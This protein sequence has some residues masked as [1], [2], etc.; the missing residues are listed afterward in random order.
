MCKKGA[1]GESWRV[2]IVITFLVHRSKNMDIPRK[3]EGKP[4]EKSGKKTI[5]NISTIESDWRKLRRVP[6]AE[7]EK[8]AERKTSLEIVPISKISNSTEG[9][10]WCVAKRRVR[11]SEEPL[12]ITVLSQR[13]GFEPSYR[14]ATCRTALRGLNYVS[15]FL[16][17]SL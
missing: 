7:G 5:A 6:P 11:L 9:K 4:P 1:H 16:R 17:T 2:C 12:P 3:L 13:V 8:R 14:S 15:C 10:L